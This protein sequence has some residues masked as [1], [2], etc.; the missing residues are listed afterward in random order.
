[1]CLVH[2]KITFAVSSNRRITLQTA[3][4][5]LRQPQDRKPIVPGRCLRGHELD[6]GALLQKSYWVGLMMQFF[7]CALGQEFIAIILYRFSF[8]WA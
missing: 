4:V 6:T 1:M 7:S 5:L 8:L 2:H 3:G